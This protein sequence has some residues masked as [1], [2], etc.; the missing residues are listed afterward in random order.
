MVRAAFYFLCLLAYPSFAQ[1]IKHLQLPVPPSKNTIV[2]TPLGSN[3]N[4]RY[5]EKLPVISPDG[6]S[7]YFERESEEKDSHGQ[8]DIYFSTLNKNGE[9]SLARNIGKPL[10]NEGHNFIF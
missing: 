1:E 8:G 5:H 3:I 2:V 6:K 7:L 4:T 9:W 10:N